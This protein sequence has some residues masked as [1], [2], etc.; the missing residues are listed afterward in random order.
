MWRRTTP[1]RRVSMTSA[2]PMA[3]PGEPA[4]PWRT[5]GGASGGPERRP[6]GLTSFLFSESSVDERADRRHGVLRGVAVGLYDQG[7]ALGAAEQQQTHHALRVDHLVVVPRGDV[8]RISRRQLR[9]L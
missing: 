2:R 3:S 7:C 5:T 4:I 8:A 6:R 1:G 9:Q